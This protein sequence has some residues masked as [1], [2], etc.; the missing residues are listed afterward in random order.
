MS[1][2]GGGS[3][4][5]LKCLK[6]LDLRS[7]DVSKKTKQG[8]IVEHTFS[9]LLENGW[10]RIFYD[11]ILKFDQIMIWFDLIVLLLHHVT[12]RYTIKQQSAKYTIWD[13]RTV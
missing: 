11:K 8:N 13:K 10:M 1:D 12:L 4:D 2:W 7:V 9:A 3:R 5:I 6:N